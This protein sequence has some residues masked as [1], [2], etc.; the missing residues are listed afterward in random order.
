MDFDSIFQIKDI[1]V[2]Q[3]L[4]KWFKRNIKNI[5]QSLIEKLIRKKKI[6]VNQKKTTSSYKLRID[7]TISIFKEK[8]SLKDLLP[9]KYFYKPTS[10][11]YNTLI[12]NIIFEND[13]FLI[14]N[15]TSGIAVQ[16][17][18]KTKKNIIDIFKYYSISKYKTPFLIHRI[19]E[20]TSGVLLIALNIKAAKV[21]SSNFA[22]R[23]VIKIY[24]AVTKGSI[25]NNNGN[26][27]NKF[28]YKKNRNTKVL[29]N[30]TSYEV[31]SKNNNFSL[32]KLE[33]K[34][35][36]KHQL[37]RQLNFIRHPI[38]GDSKYS[39]KNLDNSNDKLLLHA[40]SISFKFN[41]QKFFY[42]VNFPCYFLDFCNKNRLSIKQKL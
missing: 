40:Y 19:D 7:D 1:D 29:E 6:K 2:D 18:S 17:G 42:K 11:D 39:I 22:N 8:E 28:E 23:E 15:K 3:R 14:I 30:I 21:L 37:R 13:D 33:P 9:K 4:D 34:T 16:S 31:V 41:N 36:R 10:N 25:N 5:P 35:G 20:E 12:S 26:L 27:I 32:L 38:I 24:Y